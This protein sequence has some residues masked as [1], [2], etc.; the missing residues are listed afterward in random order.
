M[1]GAYSYDCLQDMFLIFILLLI[2]FL[3]CLYRQR[4]AFK[5]LLWKDPVTHRNNINWF[6]REA[7]IKVKNMPDGYYAVAALNIRNFKLI[8][9]MFGKKEGDDTLRYIS[10]SIASELNRDEIFSRAMVDLFFMLIRNTG[11]E[12]INIR[13][14][15]L[16]DRINSFNEGS[17]LP[18]YLAI[19][20][21]VAFIDGKN[22]DVE[23]AR[24]R[25]YYALKTAKDSYEGQC[26]F[27][28]QALGER[29]RE[30]KE[31][32]NLMIS[33]LKNRDFKVYLQPK[34]RLKD[35]MV[36]G[37]EALIR[38]IHPQ[39]GFL[40]PGDFI[41][42]AEKN[43]F[44]MNLDLFVF[45]EVCA[46]LEKWERTG[47]ISYP[48]SVNLSRRHFRILDFLDN[49]RRIR[50]NY[51]VP[52]KKIEL[53][54]TETVMF[55]DREIVDAKS[56]IEEIHRMGFLC[57]LDDF[58][59]GFSSLGLLRDLKVDTLKLDRMFF[60]ENA[61]DSRAEYIVETI[62]ALSKRL[63]IHTV[64]EGVEYMWQTEFLKSAGCD[65]VQGYV[66]AKPMPVEEF[67]KWAERIG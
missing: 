63:N 26:F 66:Y 2:F 4:R 8:N 45:E 11:E 25:A 1:S 34:I 20:R 37:A 32:T 50:D 9:D 18:Y 38:W 22:T 64:A 44:I 24:D 33:S 60:K 36:A 30:E 58:G 51:D 39:R 57:S 35:G 52:D 46:L 5:Q 41:P 13:L 40:Y 12:N 67:E 31:L 19:D 54:V 7:D 28:S 16:V 48:I 65:M 43:G 15:E 61:R 27:Y 53:E 62:I 42:V 23:E 17:E 59:F 56:V 10:G 47:K 14:K 21:G 55:S 6:R 29:L 3:Y 49:Y